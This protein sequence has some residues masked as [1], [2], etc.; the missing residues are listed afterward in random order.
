[1]GD[2]SLPHSSS[3]LLHLLLFLFLLVL[4]SFTLASPTA[5]LF[6]SP[7]VSGAHVNDTT[8]TVAGQTSLYPL[9]LGPGKTYRALV[10]D[11]RSAA[12]VGLYELLPVNTTVVDA[13]GQFI[14]NITDES[15][16]NG[17]PAVLNSLSQLLAADGTSVSDIAAF[18]T[19]SEDDTGI[20]TDPLYRCA[21]WHSAASTLQGAIGSLATGLSSGGLTNCNQLRRFLCVTYPSLE[22]RSPPPMPQLQPGQELGRVF[23]TAGT[24]TGAEARDSACQ[25]EAEASTH[26][27]L[28]PNKIYR[29]LLADS[30]NTITDILTP[31]NTALVQEVVLADLEG[32]VLGVGGVSWPP[33]ASP[34]SLSASPLMDSSGAHV[35]V[36]TGFWT[37]LFAPLFDSAR[38][39]NLLSPNFPAVHAVPFVLCSSFVLFCFATS[40]IVFFFLFF[41]PFLFLSWMAL[42]DVRLQAATMT[43]GPLR[44]LSIGAWTGTLLLVT[45]K[46]AKEHC[47]MGW[48]MVFRIVIMHGA[49]CV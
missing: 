31:P 26:P 43:Q 34:N 5:T 45:F 48:T 25:A 40:S 4:P 37:G 23:F 20:L 6:F 10:L 14:W 27:L 7:P 18:W 12:G 24:Y 39:N 8:C 38:V 15:A 30:R 28:G 9:L 36:T 42:V 33:P 44:T 1:M 21:D 49:S 46:E 19:G 32:Y 47:F 13:S 17:I 3:H 2:C 11:S 35:P 41:P 22:P 29:A 16:D